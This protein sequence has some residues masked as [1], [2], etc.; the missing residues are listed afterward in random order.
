M[1]S[2]K[3]VCTIMKL[4]MMII[5]YPTCAAVWTTAENCKI[6][7]INHHMCVFWIMI[8][9][10]FLSSYNI[11][12]MCTFHKLYTCTCAYCSILAWVIAHVHVRSTSKDSPPCL[13]LCSRLTG[14]LTINAGHSN[15][16]HAL[17][18]S[19]TMHPHIHPA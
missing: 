15:I 7:T 5:M 11:T 3:I 1:K 19:T 17:C 2:R 16:R 10:L 6:A 4:V 18:S 9:L 12:G 14:L 13:F 8:Y